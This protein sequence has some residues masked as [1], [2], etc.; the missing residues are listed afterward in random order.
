MGEFRGYLIA[1][2]MILL[3]G[4]LLAGEYLC[5]EVI[6]RCLDYRAAVLSIAFTFVIIGLILFLSI[7]DYKKH[8]RNHL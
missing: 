2:L 1:I 7:L 3:G 6:W 5:V 8:A 4:L